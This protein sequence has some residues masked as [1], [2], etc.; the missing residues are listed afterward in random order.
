MPPI[1]MDL[2][3]AKIQKLLKVEIVVPDISTW[4]FLVVIAT[5]KNG[6]PIFCVN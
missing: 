1:F 3:E 2:A 6:K 4:S 5:E